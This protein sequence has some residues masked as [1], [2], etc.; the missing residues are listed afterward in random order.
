M[1]RDLRAT[2]NTLSTCRSSDH[3]I[4][5]SRH[6]GSLQQAKRDVCVQP[7]TKTR[8]D[9]HSND[10]RSVWRDGLRI[11]VVETFDSFLPE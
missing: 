2:I 8:S 6:V 1:S 11:S 5:A 9:T 10:I 4:L 3:N 7:K